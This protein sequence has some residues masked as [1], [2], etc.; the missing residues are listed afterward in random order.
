MANDQATGV[1]GV[2][3][4]PIDTHLFFDGKEDAAT[5]EL[6]MQIAARTCYLHAILADA[7]DP[8]VA[9]VTDRRD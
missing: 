2:A 1:D 9:L 8:V 5:D 3:A 7:L 6:L 4:E